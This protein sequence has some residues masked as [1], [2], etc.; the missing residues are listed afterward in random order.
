MS[1][2]VKP[3]T[4]ILFDIGGVVVISPFQAIL[5]YEIENKIPIGYIN[6]AIQKGPHDT[7]AWQLIE[8]GEVE[9][10]DDWFASFK[11]QLTKPEVWSEYLQKQVKDG[12]TGLGQPIE[13]GKIDGHGKGVPD[14]D[15]KRLFW[16]MMKISRAPDPYMYPA[17]RKL[18]ESGRFV[19]GAFSNNVTFPEGILDEE[20]QLFTK[21]LM[22]A[23]PPNPYA[24]DSK[25]VTSNFDIFL[26]SAAVGVRKPD[27]EAYK[28]SV[29][30][31]DKIAQK[32]GL[33]RVTAEDTLFLDDI[34]INLKFAKKTGLR[35]IKVNLGRTRDAVQEL[36]K[37]VGFS[38]LD[39]KA[40]L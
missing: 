9:L 21:D 18:K 26:G 35:T 22:H 38:L 14:I 40:K 25:D 30:E 8:R 36:E 33:G 28:L 3:P 13:G 24:N 31:M 5:D 39:D 32:K 2:T 4:A 6:Y 29:R 19:L 1:N 11:K 16:R 34:G 27:P 12:A 10:N 20:G 23:P 17:L 7:G 15:A 37:Q